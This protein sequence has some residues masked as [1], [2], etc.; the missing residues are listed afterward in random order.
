MTPLLPYFRKLTLHEIKAK[1]KNCV[2]FVNVII[3]VLLKL[4]EQTELF[5]KK[6]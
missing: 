5:K 6:G 3:S 2:T 4:T 1:F